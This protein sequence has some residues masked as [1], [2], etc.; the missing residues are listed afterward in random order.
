M[1]KMNIRNGHSSVPTETPCLRVIFDRD[2]I[3]EMMRMCM[4]FQSHE[5]L[6]G[7]LDLADVL[8][9]SES[10]I[11]SI[12]SIIIFNFSNMINIS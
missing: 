1:N 7:L 8:G 3:K 10:E 9:R 5:Y 2:K 11:K 12:T 6:I 4:Q